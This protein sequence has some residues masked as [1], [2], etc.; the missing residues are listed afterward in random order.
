M[1]LHEILEIIIIHN[2][3]TVKVLTQQIKVEYFHPHYESYVVD[4]KL[5]LQNRYFTFFLTF[6]GGFRGCVSTDMLITSCFLVFT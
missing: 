4:C 5:N 3:E 2:N 1:C 6:F